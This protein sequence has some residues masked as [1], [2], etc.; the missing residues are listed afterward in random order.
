MDS[1]TTPQTQACG[2][3][4]KVMSVDARFCPECGTPASAVQHYSAENVG[5][6]EE[7]G[8]A[9]MRLRVAWGVWAGAVGLMWALIALQ[10]FNAAVWIYLGLGFVMT[11][12]VMR[13]LIEFHP[14]HNTLANVVSAKL[15]MFFAW[16]LRMLMLLLNLSINK[17][18]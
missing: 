13:R 17:A 2:Q 10:W 8:E 16:P 15:W 11:R 9:V 12:I 3:C 6:V 1:L 4:E 7:G 14:M 18:L 5:P